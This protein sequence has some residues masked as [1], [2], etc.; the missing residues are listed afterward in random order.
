MP[1]FGGKLINE[2]VAA[3]RGQIQ[4]HHDRL[5]VLPHELASGKNMTAMFK[6]MKK[7]LLKM[8]WQEQGYNTYSMQET[9]VEEQLEF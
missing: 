2:A 9:G 3:A 6:A 1:L 5:Y 7:Q 8:A 4:S